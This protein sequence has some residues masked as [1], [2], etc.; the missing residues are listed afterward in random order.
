MVYYNLHKQCLSIKAMEGPRRGRV[1]LHAQAV[2]LHNAQFKVSEAGRQRVLREKTKN[3]H[4][5][6]V[7]ELISHEPLTT[8]GPYSLAKA[9][10]VLGLARSVTYDPYRFSSFVY[11]DTLEPAY[12]TPD[13]III[14]RKILI[15]ALLSDA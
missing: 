7:G 1:I 11:R 8:E 6:V 15:P 13:C 3:V 4:A 12:D 14:G 9:A 2:Q 10:S 5:G